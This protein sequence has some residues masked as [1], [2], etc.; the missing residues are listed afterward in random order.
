MNPYEQELSDQINE[1]WD[2]G[3]VERA[4]ELHVELVEMRQLHE[5]MEMDCS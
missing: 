3:D 5:F 2:E 1:A 4:L